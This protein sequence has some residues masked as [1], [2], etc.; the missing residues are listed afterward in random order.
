MSQHHEIINHVVNSIEN[1]YSGAVT[2]GDINFEGN[3]Y[4][5]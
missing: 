2:Y 3:N 1:M 5:R 4:V